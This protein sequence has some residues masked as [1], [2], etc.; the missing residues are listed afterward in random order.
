[1]TINKFKSLPLIVLMIFSIQTKGQTSFY[2][3]EFSNDGK[4]GQ[5]QYYQVTL[6]DNIWHIQERGVILSNKNI[7]AYAESKMD[8]LGYSFI[9]IIFDNGSINSNVKVE[10][11]TNSKYYSY[12]NQKLVDSI[13]IN[14]SSLYLFD[15]PNPTFDCQNSA[16]LKNKNINQV[17]LILINWIDGSLS[18]DNAYYIYSDTSVAVHKESSKR[19][20]FFD[21]LQ[22]TII[23]KKYKQGKD[24]LEYSKIEKLPVPLKK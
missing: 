1:M 16:Y 8:S 3:A 2:K 17:N 7:Y 13:I 9:Q 12:F 20:A 14:D 19:T 6:K 24:F 11:I 23:P 21:L 15:G 4:V 18:I 10:R 22:G 5:E